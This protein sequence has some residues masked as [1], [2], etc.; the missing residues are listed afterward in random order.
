MKG[1]NDSRRLA[2]A[3]RSVGI[4]AAAI[5]GGASYGVVV[6][7]A[8]ACQSLEL[9]VTWTEVP[10][11]D[12]PFGNLVTAPIYPARGARVTVIRPYP[13]PA[14]GMFLDNNGCASAARRCCEDH[15]EICA[16]IGGLVVFVCHDPCI[17]HCATHNA[18]R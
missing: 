14:V 7:E 9:C 16:R 17:P 12:A 2:L 15:A 18:C 13:E 5:A 10:L 11:E 8:N 3:R 4:V 1:D 6:S